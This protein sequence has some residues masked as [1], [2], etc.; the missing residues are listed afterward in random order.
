MECT[1][2]SVGVKF[3]EDETFIGVYLS[4]ILLGL[5]M[6]GQRYSRCLVCSY[7]LATL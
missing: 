4:L 1:W 2:V 7:L 6:K 5:L 3:D